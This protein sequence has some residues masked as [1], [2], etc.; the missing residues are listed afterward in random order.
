MKPLH[1]ALVSETYVPEINGVAMT[2]G[3]LVDGLRGNGH[4]VNVVRPRQRADDRGEAGE[5]ALPGLPLPG[6]PGLRFGLPATG[7]LKAAW[8]AARPGRWAS[9]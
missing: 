9:R 1:L 5:L 7:R 6:Y 4:R 8:R 2:V 3:R